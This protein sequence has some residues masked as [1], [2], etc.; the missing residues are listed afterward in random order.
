MASID[1]EYERWAYGE[2]WSA[3]LLEGR[4]HGFEEGYGAGFDAGAEIGAA[5]VLLGIEHALGSHPVGS[6]PGLLPELAHVGGG[7]L[8]HPA[9]TAVGHALGAY[10]RLPW[11]RTC[12]GTAAP[13]TP[14]PGLSR[15]DGPDRAPL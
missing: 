14:A 12:A 1:V 7:Y 13:T 3:G 6:L 10:V 9:R 2:G 15:E 8:G 11:R 4:R 5:R